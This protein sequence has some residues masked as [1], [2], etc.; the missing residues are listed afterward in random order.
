M[1][2]NRVVF[3]LA[4]ICIMAIGKPQTL[5]DVFYL[6]FSALP[7]T[8]YKG[9]A[10]NVRSSFLELNAS[11][12]AVQLSKSIKWF[13]GFYFRNTNFSW[14]E[15]PDHENSFPT[16]LNDIRISSILRVELNDRFELVMIPRLMVRSDLKQQFNE[17]D[18]FGQ[19]VVLGTHAIKGN[20]NFRIG[21]G[22]ALNND[23]ERNAIIPIG[24]IYYDSKK[25]KAE[26]VYPNAHF[27]YKYSDQ[28]EFG[29]FGSVD[30]SISRVQPFFQDSKEVQ[31]FRNFQLLISPSITH[32]LFKNIYGHIKVGFSPIRYFETLDAD[33]QKVKNQRQELE[34]GLFIRTGISFRIKN[35]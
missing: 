30:G 14:N 11:V 3:P 2:L 5:N 7:Q 12:P 24:S 6:N 9:G 22:V 25:F 32:Q 27:L 34:G 1:H 28:F 18:L 31:Y 15:V 16:R 10:G 33:F 23:F 29:L 21:F 8:N 4:F 17:Q 19:A 20:P 13:N 35:Q 26:V